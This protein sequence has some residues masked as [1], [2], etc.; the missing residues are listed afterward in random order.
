MAASISSMR[1]TELVAW[2]VSE[3]KQRPIGFVTPAEKKR[4]P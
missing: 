3:P 1:W 2:L 4:N